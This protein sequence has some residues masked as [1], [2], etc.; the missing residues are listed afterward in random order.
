MYSLGSNV[1]METSMPLLNCI[2]N[3]FFPFQPIHQSDAASYH[4]HILHFC[5]VDSLLTYAPYFV[6]NYSW[7]EF[8][9]VLAAFTEQ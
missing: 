7:T 9:S 1:G 3:N 8:K 5:L 6:V 2:I 4:S